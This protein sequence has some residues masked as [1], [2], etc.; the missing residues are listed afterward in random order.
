MKLFINENVYDPIIDYLKNLGHNVLSVRHSGL[1][2]ISDDEVYKIA[3][4]ENRIIITMDKDFSK[5]FRFPPE[6]CGGIIVV[7]VYKRKVDDT[8][9]IFQKFFE[10][11]KEDDITGNLVILTSQGTRLRRRRT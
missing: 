4:R 9:R 2:G 10:S 7:K 11:L 3:C 1:S 6:S 8:L 5:S